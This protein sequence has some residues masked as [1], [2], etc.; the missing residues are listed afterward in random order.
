M[1]LSA[2]DNRDFADRTAL[3][4]LDRHLTYGEIADEAR[5]IAAGLQSRGVRQGDRVALHLRNNPQLIAAILACWWIGAIALP[6]RP[7]QS[8][9]MLIS[10]CNHLEAACLL[11]EESL[12][13]KLLPHLSELAT[14]RAIVSTGSAPP[15]DGIEPWSALLDNDGQ[16]QRVTADEREP[17][18]IVHTSGTTARAKAVGQ[19]LRGLRARARGQLA[20]I[21]FRPDDVVCVFA[22][23]SHSFGLQSLATPALAVGG[24]V[25]L[26]PEF[27]PA[28]IL[29]AMTKHGATVVGGAPGYLLALLEAARQDPEFRA[30]EFRAP[31]LRLA[32]SSS[33]KLPANFYRDWEK[34]FGASLIEGYG[35]TEACGNIL[36]NRPG[37]VGEGS[38]G[39]PFPGVTVRIVGPDGRDVPDGNIGELWCAG[40]FMFARYWNDPEA[41]ARAAGDGWFKTGDQGFRDPDGRYRIVGRTGFMIKRGGIFVSPY[42]V[43]AAFA[44]HPAVTECMA[45]GAPSEKWGQEVE[46]FVV[47]RQTTCARDLHAHAAEVLGEPSRPVRFWS[48][49]SIPKTPAGKVA[50]IELGELRASAQPLA[51]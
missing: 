19:C 9:A 48:V 16:H 44:Q 43:E 37:D 46:V 23:C 42:E 2:F 33:D 17:A 39:R 40:D 10:W 12:L 20:H 18:I 29:R 13:D 22:D 50:R 41:T 8:A 38:V 35:M 45:T 27:K 15:A 36:F 32:L 5:H 7:W 31:R 34:M 21:P 47:L 14:C 1:L 3:I 24:T 28:A 26:V 4:F 25:L 30:P 49:P 11:A 6:I 51:G